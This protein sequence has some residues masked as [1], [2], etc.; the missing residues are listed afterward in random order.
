MN[1]KY[2]YTFV[3]KDTGELIQFFHELQPIYSHKWK[4]MVRLKEHPLKKSI[5]IQKITINYQ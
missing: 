1:K 2:Y 5:K 3:Y 4:A